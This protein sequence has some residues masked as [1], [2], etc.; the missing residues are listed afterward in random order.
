MNNGPEANKRMDAVDAAILDKDV[1]DTM[2]EAL[3][4]GL[5]DITIAESPNDAEDD[6]A[7][8]A[9]EDE[10]GEDEEGYPGDDPMAG[11]TQDGFR[12]PKVAV[13][14]RNAVMRELWMKASPSQRDAVEEHKKREADSEETDDSDDNIADD[15]KKR[16]KRLRDIMRFVQLSGEFM[17]SHPQPS[18]RRSGLECTMIRL[19]DQIYEETGFVGSVCLAGPDPQKGGKLM[20]V[21]YIYQCTLSF[22]TICFFFSRIHK[23]FPDAANS[24]FA[25][26][27]PHYRQAVAD[28]M[29]AYS[30]LFSY[31]H[32]CSPVRYL[33]LSRSLKQTN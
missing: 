7:E 27:Y 29:R 16:A 5:L 15:D 22:L 33:L 14:Y 13:W 21:S 11:E 3:R 18:S 28:P 17:S 6:N 1:H 26:I 2:R 25:D 12:V 19:L 23:T 8:E 32:I 9:Q 24:S 10:G 30:S 4:A 20:T 31:V